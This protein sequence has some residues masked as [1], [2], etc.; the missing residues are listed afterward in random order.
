MHEQ[1]KPV[2]A[3]IRALRES[4]GVAPDALA[5]ALEVSPDTYAQYESGAADIPIGFLYRLAA[6]FHVELTALLTGENPRL[7]L[8]CVTRQGKGPVVE[9][10][11][12]YEHESLASN[13]V[14]KKA[15]PF[16]VTVAPRPDNTPLQHFAH[17]GQEFNYVLE[18]S[19]KVTI[20]GTH[21]IVLHA[22]DSLY[23]DSGFEHCMRAIGDQ[24]ARFLAVIL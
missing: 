1:I 5:R 12:Q 9:R 10:R 14:H 3:R 4:A 2:A 21:E 11:P 18:G 22:G 23:F 20:A 13:F 7:H 19:L 16:L 15:E 6:H 8:F 17:T 24:P